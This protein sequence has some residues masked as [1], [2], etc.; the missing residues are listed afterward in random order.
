MFNTAYIGLFDRS[1]LPM[2]LIQVELALKQAHTCIHAPIRP[3]LNSIWERTKPSHVHI[4]FVFKYNEKNQK[5]KWSAEK[6][7]GVT[8]HPAIIFADQVTANV[9]SSI[10]C[11]VSTWFVRLKYMTWHA[12][13]VM[14]SVRTRDAQEQ[15]ARTSL[16]FN[17][18]DEIHSCKWS[19]V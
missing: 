17:R 14:Y 16:I 8:E 13:H 19:R 1:L 3:Y 18:S 7:V 6:E 2:S 10:F 4:F 15:W 12:R 11:W 9:I 5:R